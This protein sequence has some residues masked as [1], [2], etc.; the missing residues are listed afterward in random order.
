MKKLTSIVAMLTII[1]AAAFLD[2]W[3]RKAQEVAGSTFVYMPLLWFKVAFTLIF[4][5]GTMGLA[6]LILL[7]M[8]R[9]K[10]VSLVFLVTGLLVLIASTVPVFIFWSSSLQGTPARIFL[11]NMVASPLSLV[12]HAGS[13]IALI[14]VVGLTPYIRARG[15]DQRLESAAAK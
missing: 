6:W 8:E 5:A 1:I 10:V 7:Q 4:A 2:Q 3:Y 13:Y 9:S 14:G 11:T 12:G 15:V